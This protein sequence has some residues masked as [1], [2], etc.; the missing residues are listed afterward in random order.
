[1]AKILIVDDVKGVRLAIKTVLSM[2]GHEFGEASSL[3]E[4][5]QLLEDNNFSYDLI[6]TDMIMPEKDGA[7]IFPY[8]EEK[9]KSIAVL[10]MSG[11]AGGVSAEMALEIAKNKAKKLL[12]KPFTTAE[13]KE[14]VS[15]AL[16]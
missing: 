11:G 14:S 1:M 9:N 7:Q 16:S 5:I 13:L 6:I 12:M 10:A 2:D 8:L 15:V 3:D 4:A